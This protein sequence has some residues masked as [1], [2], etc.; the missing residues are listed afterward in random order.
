MHLTAG[1]R[2]D[3]VAGDVVHELHRLRAGDLELTHVADVEQAAGGANDVVLVG[4]AA[5]VL[6]RHLEAGEGN[7]LGAKGNVLC[8][9]WRLE[10]R[11]V[12]GR[13]GWVLAS[14]AGPA[15]WVGKRAGD[16][17]RASMQYAEVA[18]SEKGRNSL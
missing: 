14:G 6:H 3:V 11:G 4:D 17:P 10:Q 16:I 13:H 2:G 9:E 8:E 7:H 15:V 5:G 18:D 1:E 12:F